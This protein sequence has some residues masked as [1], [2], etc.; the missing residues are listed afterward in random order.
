MRVQSAEIE[1]VESPRPFRVHRASELVREFIEV[2]AQYSAQLGR[3]LEVNPTD[4]QAM[5]HLIMSGP[6]SPTE[7]ARRLEISTAAATAVVDRLVAV[8]HATREQHPSDRRSIVVVPRPESVDR[9]MAAL[10]PMILGID[11]VLDAFDT[12]QQ[13]TITEYLQRIVD[14]YRARLEH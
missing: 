4:L 13:Q 7:L 12:E 10:M 14:A 8:G 11:R 2:N 1:P 9:A 5:Q 3:E 6:L